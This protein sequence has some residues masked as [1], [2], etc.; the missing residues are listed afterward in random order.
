M[1]ILT[2]L[3]EAGQ[4][5]ISNHTITGEINRR[6]IT[7][8]IQSL[9]AGEALDEVLSTPRKKLYRGLRDQSSQ[10]LLQDTIASVRRAENTSNYVT[11]LTEMLPSW[12]RANI[13]P[14]SKIVSCT[15]AYNKA[16]QY[17][18]PYVA[19]PTN[20]ASCVYTGAH[21][22][23][24][25][26]EGLNH[27]F[28]NSSGTGAIPAVNEAFENYAT[29]PVHNAGSML[30][31][32]KQ[33][34]HDLET[35]KIT[36]EDLNPELRAL[37]ESDPETYDILEILDNLMDPSH[38][39]QSHNGALLIPGNYRADGEEVQVGG[40]IVFI[41]CSMFNTAFGVEQ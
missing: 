34:E 14:R 20:G 8:K 33:L 26:F 18:V 29:F 10:I 19:L 1:K 32:C 13:L 30:K 31:L 35:G 15:S 9:G 39:R 6:T 3:S 27:I 36:E 16:Y 11:L 38:M 28:N 4:P 41:E 22:F 2:L 23:W 12:K 40:N 5:V 25:A 24:D 17:G 21:D 37:F 7:E